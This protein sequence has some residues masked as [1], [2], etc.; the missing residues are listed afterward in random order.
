[1][2]NHVTVVILSQ[3]KRTEVLTDPAMHVEVA[4][5]LSKTREDCLP[6]AKKKKHGPRRAMHRKHENV[7]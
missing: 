6:R 7:I 2:E 5:S 1:M 4:T 3:G